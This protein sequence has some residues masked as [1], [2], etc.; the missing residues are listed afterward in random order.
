MAAMNVAEPKPSAICPKWRH[1]EVGGGGGLDRE[2]LT[3]AAVEGWGLCLPFNYPLLTVKAKTLFI[4]NEYGNNKWCQQ[5]KTDFCCSFPFLFFI[6]FSFWRGSSVW[7]ALLSNRFSSGIADVACPTQIVIQ[8][9]WF[10]A[11][12]SLYTMFDC[13]IP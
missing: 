10:V 4:H 7:L 2:G 5:M 9:I 3:R 13:E 8:Y 6:P 11:F 12:Y 1:R